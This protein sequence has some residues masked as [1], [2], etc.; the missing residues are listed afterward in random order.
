TIHGDGAASVLERV[1]TDL[2]V[3]AS[4]FAATDLL[5]TLSASERR[6]VATIEEV[7]HVDGEVT[8][9]SLFELGPDGAEPTG[10]IDRGNS[11]LVASLAGPDESYADVLTALDEREA[12][13]ADLA[14]TERTAPDEVDS[15]HRRRV[16]E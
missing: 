9:E 5:V 1:V 13:L 8:F 10:V 3:P 6:C 15:A 4:S 12:L 2:D 7:R 16:V 11:R 14:A